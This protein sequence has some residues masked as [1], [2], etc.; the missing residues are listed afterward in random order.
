LAWFGWGQDGP[1]AVRTAGFVL[2]LSVAVAGL[3]SAVHCRA[4]PTPIPGSASARMYRT[5]VGAEFVAAGVGAVALGAIGAER[6]VAAWVCLVIGIHL[7]ALKY[8]FHGRGMEYLATATSLVGVSEFV[9]AGTGVLPSAVT[10]CGAGLCVLVHAGSMLLVAHRRLPD[11]ATGAARALKMLYTPPV[12][13]SLPPPTG[14]GDPG[15]ST[16]ASA[17]PDHTCRC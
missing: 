2:A 17:R 14:S 16:P 10:G 3:A 5:V 15:A 11:G 13:P 4:E 9:V 12:L 1:P 6:F 8:L 7:V